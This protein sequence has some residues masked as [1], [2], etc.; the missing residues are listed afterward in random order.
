MSAHLL[1]NKELDFKYRERG[2]QTNMVPEHRKRPTEPK[3]MLNLVMGASDIV[4]ALKASAQTI[5]FL[6][7]LSFEDL[8]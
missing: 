4:E 2:R 1:R 5:T 8:L 7:Q 3:R 6:W